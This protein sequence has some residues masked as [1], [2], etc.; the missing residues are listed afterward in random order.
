M[1]DSHDH[2]VTNVFALDAFGGGGI[3]YGLAVAAVEREGDPDLVAIVT[4]DFEAVRAPSQVRLI[5]ADALVVT[6]L[7]AASM[8]LERQ[9]VR[10]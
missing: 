4:S 5:D 3:A 7:V 8:P 1:L 2:E 9:I 6:A 10:L